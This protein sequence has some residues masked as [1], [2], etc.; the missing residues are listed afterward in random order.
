MLRS[1]PPAG[2]TPGGTRVV[3][4]AVVASTGM[5]V[6][7]AGWMIMRTGSPV[8]PVTPA[9]APSKS[10]NDR[11]AG[12]QAR[13]RSEAD[14]PGPRP[15]QDTVGKDADPP[16]ADASVRRAVLGPVEAGESELSQ[17]WDELTPDERTGA[18]R[19][20]LEAALTG[21]ERHGATAQRIAKAESAL[22]DLRAVLYASERGRAEHQ[23]YEARLDA[24]Q[25]D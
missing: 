18:L 16:D 7:V 15:A 5:V 12:P 9:S 17:T 11:S 6:A 13:R 22:S 2:G 10:S 4:V 3:R 23:G 1:P 14:E 20:R 21:I 24:A 19:D 8:T 25:R